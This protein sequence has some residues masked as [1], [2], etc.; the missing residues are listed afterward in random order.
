ML[1]NE[2]IS[3][4]NNYQKSIYTDF[5]NNLSLVTFHE[6]MRLRQESDP[7]F[8]AERY[9]KA[10]IASWFETQK[11][12]CNAQVNDF[13][14]TIFSYIKDP[15]EIQEEVNKSLTMAKKVVDKVMLANG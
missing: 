1:H 13:A 15:E 5:L 3:F 10:L 6:L 4:E 14:K 9:K 2:I 7:S 8:E 12:N 11:K